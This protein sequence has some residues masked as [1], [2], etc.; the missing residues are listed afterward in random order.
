MTRFLFEYKVLPE[1]TMGEF[2][3]VAATEEEARIMVRERV[4]DLEFVDEN[5]IQVGKLIK[6]LNLSENRY[7][8]CEGCQ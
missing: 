4:A 6:T 7:F 3:S 5:E 2:S 1:N 8:E